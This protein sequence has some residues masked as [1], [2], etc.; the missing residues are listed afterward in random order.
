M[1][2]LDWQMWFAALGGDCR[3][4]SWFLAFEQRLLEGSP[5]AIGLLKDNPF[6][7]KPPRYL[8]AQLY[9]YRFTGRGD[10]SW[11]RR[12]EAGPFCPALGL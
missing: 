5:E 9:R 4:Q 1:P 10:R 2:R 6:P 8:R 7:A 3:T 11:W 12:E